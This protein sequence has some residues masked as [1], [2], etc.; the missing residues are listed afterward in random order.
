MILAMILLIKVI[1]LLDKELMKCYNDL[2]CGD[3]NDK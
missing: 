2:N 3:L 1:M